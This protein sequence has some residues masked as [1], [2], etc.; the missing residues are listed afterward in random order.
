MRYIA[1]QQQLLLPFIRVDSHRHASPSLAPVLAT[2]VTFS[3]Q[4]PKALN[5]E[6]AWFMKPPAALEPLEQQS[7]NP[8]TQSAAGGPSVGGATAVMEEAPSDAG[9]VTA[10]PD[11][12]QFATLLG[13]GSQ[14]SIEPWLT[15]SRRYQHTA[16]PQSLA[17]ADGSACQQAA[18]SA[19][20]ANAAPPAAT[21]SSS[22]FPVVFRD[23]SQPLP[24][25]EGRWLGRSA[26]AATS[27]AL[28][29][30]GA[31]TP[32]PYGQRPGMPQGQLAT[33]LSASQQWFSPL[34]LFQPAGDEQAEGAASIPANN[35]AFLAE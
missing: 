3:H 21:N 17:S 32:R 13:V 15:H 23:V 24:Q 18:P 7:L 9:V 14:G 10:E 34:E 6:Q 20:A 8:L 11:D 29:M 33:P 5:P 19:A 30:S 31:F 4:A 27:G 28:R 2:G 12:Q 35:H 16:H 1:Q 25:Q 26:E 22:H